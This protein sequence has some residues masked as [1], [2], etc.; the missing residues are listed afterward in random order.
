MVGLNFVRVHEYINML[1]AISK[2]QTINIDHKI[3][4]QALSLIV[5]YFIDDQQSPC[6]ITSNVPEP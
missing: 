5:D 1:N 4:H 6:I 3:Q 2:F